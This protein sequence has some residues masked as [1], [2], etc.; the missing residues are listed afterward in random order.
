MKVLGKRADLTGFVAA[1]AAQAEAGVG[2]GGVYL[3]RLEVVRGG[4][5]EGRVMLPEDG[6]GFLREP[7]FVAELEGDAGSR[8]GLEGR[9][10]KE[11][12]Q[13]RE[14]CLEVGRQLNKDDAKLAGC[15]RRLKRGEELRNKRMAIAQAA[16][17]RDALW[18]LEGEAEAGRGLVEPTLELSWLKG[19]AEGVVDLDRGELGGV[20]LEEL[21]CRG[22][23][24]CKSRA[25][26]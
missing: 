3:G 12:R 25:S 8:R 1:V 15:G 18:S 23:R 26:R 9:C 2:S 10:G 14:V 21:P 13:A 17:V 24:G 6:V 7:R 22:S 4:D 20:V 16:E 19:R 5:A 11:V